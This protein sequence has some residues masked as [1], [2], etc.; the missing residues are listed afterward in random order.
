[1]VLYVPGTEETDLK[2]IIMSLQLIAGQITDIQGAW[3]NYTPTVTSQGGT[4]TTV[5]ATGRYK[6][7]GKT[8]LVEIS[9]TI[10]DKGTATGVVFATLPVSAAAYNFAGSVFEYQTTG[11]SGA[12][13]LDGV[14]TPSKCNTRDATGTEWWVNGYRLAYSMTYEAP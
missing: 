12:C 8:V 4:P 7:I 11:K 2:K 14:S 10:T 13:Y 9:V 6:Q 5:S 3:S 1:M